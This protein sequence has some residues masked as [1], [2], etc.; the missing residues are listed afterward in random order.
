MTDRP[1]SSDDFYCDEVISGR[2]EVDRVHETASVLAF[3]H[4]RPSYAAHIVVIPK[5][6]VASLL[7]TDPEDSAEMMQV[8]QEVAARVLEQY[9][10]C[11]V[12]TNLGRYQESKHVHWHVVA[13]PAQA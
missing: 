13:D 9:G 2:T 5:R 1:T 8:V 7:D 11:R 12:V 10:A 4:T 6:H 3:H